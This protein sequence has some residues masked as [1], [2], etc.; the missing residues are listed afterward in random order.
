ME[1]EKIVYEV[2]EY[3]RFISLPI[4]RVG[5]INIDIQVECSIQDET[6]HKN[7]DFIA[8]N[9]LGDNFQVVRIPAGEMYGFCDIEIIDDDLN[10]MTTETFR[11]VLG[12]SA[13]DV[14]IGLKSEAQISIIGPNDGKCLNFFVN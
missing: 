12:N 1:F 7:L 3:Q 13:G 5:D 2:Q 14:K 9:K 8:R 6:A 10:E 11:A 4:V